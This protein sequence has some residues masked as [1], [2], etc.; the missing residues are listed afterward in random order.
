MTMLVR[1]YVER[2]SQDQALVATIRAHLADLAKVS[3]EARDNVKFLGTLERHFKVLTHAPL[4][5]VR[6]RCLLAHRRLPPRWL[7]IR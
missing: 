2:F 1:R 5:S 7:C 4:A 6:L 3:T